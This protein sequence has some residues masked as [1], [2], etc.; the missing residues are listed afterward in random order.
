[1]SLKETASTKYWNTIPKKCKNCIKAIYTVEDTS[2]YYQCSLFGT[3]KRD[4]D[5]EAADRSLPKPE[6]ILEV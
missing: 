5:V 4:C 3:F 1:M 6:D 2:V